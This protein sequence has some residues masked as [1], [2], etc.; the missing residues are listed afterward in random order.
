VYGQAGSFTTGTC[1]AGG[2][3][4]YTFC[5]SRGVT[6]D[7][8][9]DLYVSDDGNGRILHYDDPL[10]AATV[11][12]VYGQPDFL[13]T[14]CGLSAVRLCFPYGLDVDPLGGLYVADFGNSRVVHYYPPLTDTGGDHA[15]GQA[16]LTGGTC[17]MSTSI[18]PTTI[19]LPRS[20]AVDGA[21]NIFVA[22]TGNHRVLM[23]DGS[24]GCSL[25]FDCDGVADGADVDDDGDGDT[26]LLDNCQLVYNAMQGNADAAPLDN[27]PLAPGNDTTILLSDASGD[28]CDADDDNDGMS[29]ASEATGAGCTGTPTIRV[30]ID[31]DGD[32]LTD[33][34][35]CTHGSNP[36]DA[37]SKFP[38]SGSG[39]G[40]ADRVTDLWEQRG[41]NASSS[42]TDS[43][44][45]GCHDLVEAASIDGNKTI[46]DSDRLSVARRALGIW[47]AN[48]AQDYVLDIDK[49]GVVGDADRLFA[50]RAAVLPDWL[51]KSCP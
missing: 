15:L 27:G 25:D 40:D 33:G 19:C 14:G 42:N 2:I 51:P 28:A 34:W 1:N 48:V 35:E 37:M 49:N 18:G 12:R 24:R 3:G 30:R 43:D 4:A 10:G 7:A 31:S 46:G 50:A 21:G 39:D 13:G 38:G 47:G 22:D 6:V 16:T 23:F 9:N 17:N 36:M 29:D 41:Y 8:S 44:A 45:D 11:D 5:S 20:V 26:D 32:H